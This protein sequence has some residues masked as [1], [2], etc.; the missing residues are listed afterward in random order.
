MAVLA[1]LVF[2]SCV[3]V[4]NPT[5][6]APVAFDGDTAYLMTSKGKLSES[7]STETPERRAGLSLIR[8]A[9]KTISS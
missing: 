3:R 4:S 6:W 1:L 5:G 8:I 7:N 9:T 2:S